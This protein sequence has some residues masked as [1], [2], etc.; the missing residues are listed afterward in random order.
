MRIRWP[1]GLMTGNFRRR[2]GEE[3]WGSKWEDLLLG[4]DMEDKLQCVAFL[5]IH[6]YMLDGVPAVPNR[7]YVKSLPLHMLPQ[8]TDGEYYLG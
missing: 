3:L 5:S 2:A 7:Q 6:T 8:H 1:D 4:G